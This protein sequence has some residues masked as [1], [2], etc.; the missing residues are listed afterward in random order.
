M[1]FGYVNLI[2][3]KNL[4]MNIFFNFVYF[5]SSK[6][7]NIDKNHNTQYIRFV[8]YF[9]L[10]YFILYILFLIYFIVSRHYN[11]FNIRHFILSRIIILWLNSF[12]MGIYIS[13]YSIIRFKIRN[14]LPFIIYYIFIIIFYVLLLINEN[15]IYILHPHGLYLY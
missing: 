2:L 13:R 5:I 9:I 14:L 10:P 3:Q 8:Y 12:I 15:R 4:L 11:F 7:L 1:L 6:L